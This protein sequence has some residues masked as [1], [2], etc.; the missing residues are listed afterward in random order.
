MNVNVPPVSL[1]LK[2]AWVPVPQL[3]IAAPEEITTLHV[4][5]TQ[6]GA[7]LCEM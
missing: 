6:V 1:P 5:S 7:P 4:S 3:P 2:K